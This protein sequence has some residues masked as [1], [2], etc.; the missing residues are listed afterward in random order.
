MDDPEFDVEVEVDG[1]RDVEV[2]VECE[3]LFPLEALESL[4]PATAN[5][6]V[7]RA[8]NKILFFIEKSS[9]IILIKR[10]N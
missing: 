6:K 1:D 2:Y 5:I 3:V 8:N 4:Q 9:L 7:D 10:L